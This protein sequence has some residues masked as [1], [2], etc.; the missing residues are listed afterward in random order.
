M[1]FP[2]VISAAKS[3]VK[4]PILLHIK[5]YDWKNREEIQGELFF[6]SV[7]S[8]APWVSLYGSD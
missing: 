2:N 4:R 6:L 3:F 5:T 7:V 1:I 8:G